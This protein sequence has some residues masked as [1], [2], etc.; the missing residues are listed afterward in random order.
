[1]KHVTAGSRN[2]FPINT[3]IEIYMAATGRDSKSALL[4]I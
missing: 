3:K 4:K 2:L 1:M